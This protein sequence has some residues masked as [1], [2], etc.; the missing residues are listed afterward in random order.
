MRTISRTL[1]Y[2]YFALSI[3]VLGL[4][5]LA[6]QPG[7]PISQWLVTVAVAS[8]VFAIAA[9]VRRFTELPV[10]R[11]STF[12]QRQQQK[13]VFDLSLY[14]AAALGIL[15][16]LAFVPGSTGDAVQLFVGALMLGYYASLDLALE[17]ELHWFQARNVTSPSGF[18]M[19]PAARRQYV[20]S[21]LT[22]LVSAIAIMLA[23]Y[24][25]DMRR[26]AAGQ[27]TSAGL[28]ESLAGLALVVAVVCLLSLRIAHSYFRNQQLLITEQL[29]IMSAVQA[30][31]LDAKLPIKS[32]DEFGVLARQINTLIDDMREKKREHDILEHT[33]SPS[34]MNKLLASDYSQ[35]RH[36]QEYQ[37]AI[38]F[39]DMRG[40]T[41]MAETAGADEIIRFLNTFFSDLADIVGHNNGIIN[42]FM[43]DAIL[44]I[45]GLDASESA[46][47][48]AVQ[49]AWE[50]LE[51]IKTYT[52]PDGTSPEVGSGIHFGTV[53]AGTIGSE[54]RYEYTFLGD[55]VN[56]ASRLEGLSKRLAHRVIVSSSAFE[57]L[58]E[59]F[60]QAFVD[61]G[62]HHVRGKTDAVHVF[63][64]GKYET[65]NHSGEAKA[66]RR[67]VP[68][69]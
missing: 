47:D 60:R 19:V 65:S 53:V 22:L 68:G 23:F 52:L 27:H 10:R 5:A 15:L 48:D 2:L 4:Y 40:F 46:V 33:L 67:Q 32:R 54:M 16:L 55:A 44:A 38:L 37:V 14:G 35:L 43:G 34:I 18:T 24:D 20:F 9:L 6:R 62:M 66:V 30:G 51:R 17:R 59:Q 1:P 25:L 57:R 41:G 28:S 39:C 64:G 50:I 26:I 3:I 31:K 13:F 42:K 12:E 21:A 11:G 58:G 45:Y 69:E 36:G 29:G 7:L 56:T 8:L 49:S 63:G 61:L